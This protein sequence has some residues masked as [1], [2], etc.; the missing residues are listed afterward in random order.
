MLVGWDK[1]EGYQKPGLCWWGARVHAVLCLRRVGEGRLKT[2][3][4]ATW[5]PVSALPHARAW[6]EW[7]LHP[8]LLMERLYT[9]SGVPTQEKEPGCGIQR[10]L[11]PW[12]TSR[13]NRG[14][15]YWH[16]LRQ[17]FRSNLEYC[18]WPVHHNLPP[19]KYRETLWA[20]PAM[21]Q[22]STTGQGQWRLEGVTSCEDKEDFRH[23][24][25]CKA[26]E[27]NNCWCLHRWHSAGSLDP[28]DWYTVAHESACIGPWGFSTALLCGKS[29]TKY[30]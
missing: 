20:P 25:E 16:R 17:C 14:C 23:K 4:L 2:A 6:A 24:A 15:N 11:G 18:W 9:I 10:Q 7:K 28:S 3:P 5:F 22:D 1:Q 26:G 12:A 29:S 27:G 13:W 21:W 30:G 8:H 19:Y